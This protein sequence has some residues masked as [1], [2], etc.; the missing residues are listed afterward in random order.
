MKSLYDSKNAL[1]PNFNEAQT[2]KEF[3]QPVLELLGYEDSYI[4]QTSAKGAKQTGRPDYALYLDEATKNKAYKG[5]KDVDYGQCIGIA[6]AKHWDRD[7]DLS[8][9]DSKDTLTNVNPSFQIVSYLTATQ[10]RWGI[11]TNGRLW[12]LYFTR[13]H[14]P[15]RDCYQVDL[16]QILE[17]G[18]EEEIKWFLLFF[19]RNSLVL[20]L[21]N[22]SFLDRVVEGSN[23]YAV[24]LEAHIKER[25]FEVVEYV[26]RGFAS[27]F[28]ASQLTDDVLSQIYDNSLILLYRL[29]FV[30]YAEARELLPLATNASYR[31]NYSLTRI[32]FAMNEVASKGQALSSQSTKHY[33]EIKQLFHMIATGD[34]GVGIPEYNGRPL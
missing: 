21:D 7:L 4:V 25:A 24:E 10:T 14:V 19:C 1:L 11:V 32:A 22:R 28:P 5:P 20:A 2:E 26:S 34:A 16:A 12:R 30:F 27:T 9:A 6:D 18:T 17:Q 13:S 23:E 31:D 15:L 3:I 33:Q 29:L 8:K